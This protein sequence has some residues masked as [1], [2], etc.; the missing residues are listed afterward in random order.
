MSDKAKNI[1]HLVLDALVFDG[2]RADLDDAGLARVVRALSE[3][4]ARGALAATL[5]SLFEVASVL[6]GEGHAAA[7]E[8]LLALAERFLPALEREV[9]RAEGRTADRQRSRHAR[10]ARFSGA[11]AVAPRMAVGGGVRLA[12]LRPMRPIS[13]R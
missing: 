4:E 1:G 5:E 7:V 12:D 8:R 11:T 2:G 13:G 9:A 3:A 6:D 10:F